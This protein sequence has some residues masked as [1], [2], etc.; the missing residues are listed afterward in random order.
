MPLRAGAVPSVLALLLAIAPAAAQEA[1]E[2]AAA[3]ERGRAVFLAAS[4]AACHTEPEEGERLAGGRALASPFGTFFTPN[5]TPDPET[6]I[7]NWSEADLARALHEGRAPD[8]SAYYP[9]FPYTSYTGMS[10]RDVSDLWAYLQTLDPVE[11]SNR[12]HDLSFPFGFRLLLEPWRWLYFAPVRFTPDPALDEQEARGAYLVEALGHCAECHTPRN[13]F[14]A[15]NRSRAYAGTRSG[16]DG[17]R[18]SNIT[19]HENGLG[20]WSAGE[21]AYYL[22]TGFTPDFDFAGGAMAEVI[23]T[24]TSQM[25]D[26]D[27]RAIAAY[28]KRLPPLP[29][30]E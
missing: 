1:E 10:D 18:V 29:N 12:E 2:G 27:R 23:E 9:A 3:V 11:Q 5:I 4:C 21:I 6:G 24:S 25:S 19:P 15:L 22:E 17:R 28:L 13:R 16:P 30:P 8:G 26:E 7:G 14:G 20:G